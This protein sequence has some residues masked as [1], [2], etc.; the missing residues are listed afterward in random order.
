MNE[1]R[2]EVERQLKWP[3]VF[4]GPKNEV[5]EFNQAR[6]VPFGWTLTPKRRKLGLSAEKMLQQELERKKG[7]KWQ[8]L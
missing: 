7:R 4:Y 2:T 6:D 3:R 5:R 1:T 8:Q